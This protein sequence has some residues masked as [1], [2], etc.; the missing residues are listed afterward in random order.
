MPLLLAG[1]GWGSRRQM[2]KARQ[3]LLGSLWSDAGEPTPRTALGAA[4]RSASQPHPARAGGLDSRQ[5]QAPGTRVPTCSAWPRAS[6]SLGPPGASGCTALSRRALTVVAGRRALTVV[7]GRRACVARSGVSA[8]CAC[9]VPGLS[10]GRRVLPHLP[11]GSTL[12]LLLGPHIRRGSGPVA[13]PSSPSSP[14]C[15]SCGWQTPTQL[16]L[17]RSRGFAV[18]LVAD[19]PPRAGPNAKRPPRLRCTPPWPVPTA[20]R[21]YQG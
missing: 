2:T 16:L 12:A 17:A 4:S 5:P 18:K 14:Q 13:G 6:G 9:S 20:I 10:R 19:P 8:A 1:L 7:A 21:S 15:P 3:A 11:P